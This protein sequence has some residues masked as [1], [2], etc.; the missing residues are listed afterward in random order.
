MSKVTYFDVSCVVFKYIDS[1][2]S[3]H[4]AQCIESLDISMSWRHGEEEARTDS[5]E[6]QSVKYCRYHR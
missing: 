6:G 1:Y 5:Q 4:S 2:V 3:I